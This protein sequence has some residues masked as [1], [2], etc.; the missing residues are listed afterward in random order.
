METFK[1][2][3]QVVPRVLATDLDGTFIPL[4]GDGYSQAALKQIQEACDAHR[5]KLVFAT[6]RHFNSVLEVMRE[7]ALPTPDWIVCDVGTSIYQRTQETFQLYA[8]FE[9]RLADQTRGTDRAAIEAMLKDIGDITLQSIERQQRFKISYECPS[10]QIEPLVADI[11]RRLSTTNTPFACLGSIDPFEGHGLLDVLP[12]CASKAS[13]LIWLAEHTDFHPDEVVFAGDS[14]NDLAALT[15]G[16]RAI[17]VANA[18]PGLAGQ[19][20]RELKQRGLTE[21]CFCASRRSTAG[22]LEGIRHFGLL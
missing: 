1:P 22:V 7:Q 5:L 11:N 17:V 16:F 15:C 12:V 4:P 18:A 20:K 6:G 8:P 19:V 2:D 21:R 10:E 13:A 3:P 9:S 14:G